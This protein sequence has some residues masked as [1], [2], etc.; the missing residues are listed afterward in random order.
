MLGKLAQLV[1]KSFAGE[2]ADPP[3]D[4]QPSAQAA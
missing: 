4:V 2:A 1:R 3:K